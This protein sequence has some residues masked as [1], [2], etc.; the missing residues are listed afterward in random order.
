[1]TDA[2]VPAFDVAIRLA[3]ALEAAALPYAIGGAIAL[4]VWSDPRATHDVDLNLFVDHD[5]LPD[6]LDV[7]EGAGLVIARDA[8]LRADAEGDVL[9]GKYGAMRVD[10]FTPSIPFAWEAMRTRRRVHGPSGEAFF[11]SAEATAV[12]KLLFFRAKDLVD[13]EKL[14]V[15]QGRD[16]DRPYVR[17][18]LVDMMGETDERTTA[19]DAITARRPLES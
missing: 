10:I 17:R 2:L 8:A 18:W 13:V 4:G 14:V 19:W 3:A 11:L 5:A 16:L 7:L 12:F 9:I 6:A 1:V 15:V